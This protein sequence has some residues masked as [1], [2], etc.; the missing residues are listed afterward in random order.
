M[1]TCALGLDAFGHI[2]TTRPQQARRTGA[3]PGPQ[4]RPTELAD[5]RDVGCSKPSP[6]C[7]TRWAAT[8]AHA[9]Q[10]RL[11]CSAA[12]DGEGARWAPGQAP[13]GTCLALGSDKMSIT[14][15]CRTGTMEPA[16]RSTAMDWLKPSG[17]PAPPVAPPCLPTAR[18]VRSVRRLGPRQRLARLSRKK[19]GKFPYFPTRI[20]GLPGRPERG[21]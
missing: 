5:P 2:A 7:N 8:L 14:A 20:L 13:S 16:W 6:S 9:A 11:G 10:Y 19:K 17:W 1:G 18:R 3:R 15:H 21:L 4:A 12:R